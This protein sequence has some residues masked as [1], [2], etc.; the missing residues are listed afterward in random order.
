MKVF[1]LLAFYALSLFIIG[2]LMLDIETMIMA[3][4]ANQVEI[5]IPENVLLEMLEEMKY[6]NKFSIFFTFFIL[7]IKCFLMSLVLYAGLFFANSHQGVK[8]GSLFK[9]AVYAESIIV[10]AGMVKVAFGAL[11]DFT[12]TEFSLF[13]PLS[14][15]SFLNPEAIQP[16]CYYPL[17][18]LNVFEII[19]IFLLIYFFSQEIEIKKTESSKVVL[20]S[21]LFSMSFWLILILFLTLNFT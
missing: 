12:Y 15:L 10:L 3:E 14:V 11:S 4:L 9:V 2:F 1:G 5:E 17:Q 6:W 20:G 13:Y 18:L 16:L 8:L 19:Y 7:S 21:Y